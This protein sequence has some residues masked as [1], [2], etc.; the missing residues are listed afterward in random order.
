M[1]VTVLGSTG[2]IGRAV[3]Q[4]LRSQGHDVTCP[5]RADL[6]TLS[7]KDQEAVISCLASR[8]GIP[9]D[10]WAVDH[11]L[12][13]RALDAAQRDGVAKFILLSALCVH[14]P[15]LAFLHAALAFERKLI[16]APLT[17]VIIRPT[18]F[19]KSLSGQM[20][21]VQAGKPFLTFG[22]GTLTACKPISDGDLA[23]FVALCL[24]DAEKENRILPIGGPG[25]AIT[26]KDQAKM[27][28]K[29]LGTPVATRAVPPGFLRAVGW[30]L[31]RPGRFAPGLMEKAALARIGHYYATES[32]LVWDGAR[33][34]ADATPEFGSDTLEEHYRALAQGEI[35]DDRGAHAVF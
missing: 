1:T 29:V 20:A 15:R 8:T 24:T 32:M 16:D 11:D 13:A 9:R 19:F 28:E 27:L 31:D 7:L 22:N 10:A 4:E 23:R 5:G 17:H 26:P 2:T 33:Y 25:P 30:L 6:A 12:N 34:D 14:K 18:A 3:A 35:A 21:R